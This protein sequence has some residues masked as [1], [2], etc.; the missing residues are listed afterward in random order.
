MKKLFWTIGIIIS[1]SIAYYLAS[2]LFVK[3][4]VSEP[5]P[6][7]QNS[8]EMVAVNEVF[9]GEFDGLAGHDASGTVRLIEIDGKKIIRF[10][11]NFKVTNGPDLFVYLGKDGKY[12]P[13]TKLGSLKGNVGSQNYDLP[14]SID[15]NQY[16]EV[17]VWCRAFSVPFAKAILK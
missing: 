16:K 1:L 3:K 9:S 17:W 12:A 6:I 8:A 14:I 4:E 10:E 2:P 15:L 13:E 7:N 11:D 5:L